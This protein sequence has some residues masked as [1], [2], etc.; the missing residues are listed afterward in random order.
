MPSQLE[1]TIARFRSQLL[2][3]DQQA[4]DLLTRA[5]GPVRARLLALID[6]L[7]AEIGA[8]GLTEGTAVLKLERAATLLTQVEQEVARLSTGANALITA[9]QRQAIQLAL[10]Q[11]QA[12]VAA[13]DARIALAWHRVPTQAVAELVGRLS[14]GSPLRAYLDGL[15]PDAS[16]AIREGLTTGLALG[17]H[18]QVIAAELAGKVDLSMSRL[19]MTTRTNILNSYRGATLANYR[20]NADILDG[21]IWIATL[22]ER[23][24][25][26]CLALHGQHFGLDVAFQPTHNACRCS[27]IPSLKGIAPPDLQDGAEWFDGQ[28]ATVQDGILGKRAGSAFRNGEVS[29]DDFAQ[30]RKDDRWGD[31]YVQGS[32]EQARASAAGRERKAA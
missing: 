7:V 10:T 29:L 13:Q 3:G 9:G 30:L 19:L 1:Q 25:G 20:A 15:G 11:A 22:S 27:S 17:Q 23:T 31:A 6:D 28:P 32:L 26:A 12:L 8:K 14:D 24:C 5:Y 16:A 21:W 4:L 2:S 18:P